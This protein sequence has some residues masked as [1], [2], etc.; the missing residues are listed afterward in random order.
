MHLYI[1]S[2]CILIC[3]LAI[4]GLWAIAAILLPPDKKRN[5]A[6][7]VCGALLATCGCIV[8]F[9]GI[10]AGPW[11]NDPQ[12]IILPWGLPFGQLELCLDN[13]SKVF[14]LP[15]FGL[16]AVCALAGLAALRHERARE[17]NLGA[18]WFFYIMLTIGMAMVLCARDAILFLISWEI[19]SLAPFFLVDFNDQQS[20]VR[21]AAWT[22]LAAAH[23]G[24]IFLIAFFTLL[25]QSSG[26]ASFAPGEDGLP[27][28]VSHPQLSSLLFILALLGFG[29]KA[30]IVPLHVW[31]P[32]AHPAAPGHISAL[33]SGA[34]INIGLYGI[35][36]TLAILCGCG[37]ATAGVI[38]ACPAW[39]GWLVLII[40]LCTALIGILKAMGQDN[41]KRLLAYSSVENMGLMFTGVG[42]GIIGTAQGDAWIALAAFAGAILHMLNHSCFKGLLFLCSSEILHAVG[43]VRMSLLGGLQKS[44]PYLGFF[45]LTGAW[46]IACLPPLNGFSGEFVLLFS[47]INGATAPAVESRLGLLFSAVIVTLV[48]GVACAV[49]AMAYSVIFS[50]QP[51]SSFAASPHKPDSANLWPLAILGAACVG[52]GV[53]SPIFF[54]AAA[55][56]VLETAPLAKGILPGCVESS[57][58]ISTNLGICSLISAAIII[59]T[60]SLY[61]LRKIMLARRNP[62]KTRVWNCGYQADSV[63][64]QYSPASFM[65]PL[66]RIFNFISGIERKG[67]A[68]K[69]IFPATTTIELSAPDRIRAYFYVPIFESIERACNA[70][71]ILQHGKIHLYILY[72]LATL[73]ALLIWGLHS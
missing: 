72:I 36:R 65:Q 67:D 38:G 32:E 14:L 43:T 13:L 54:K 49:Y 57:A 53:C 26:H 45:F 70:C 25:W 15:V 19:M 37:G 39:W 21:D 34:M 44:L 12:T 1:A 48:S 47:L 51:R 3:A 58:I 52:G 50:G 23:L 5:R 42:A 33:L 61:C 20:S 73:I 16:G 64:L 22:Y 6:A 60:A 28:I 4:T 63:R 27:Y 10:V 9:V 40:G 7:G 11:Q 56:A 29:A 8:G 68:P 69:G 59:L 2:L 24:A 31:L 62:Q 66:V 55:S 41:L 17:H 71:K 18:H 46:A 30:G 35:L